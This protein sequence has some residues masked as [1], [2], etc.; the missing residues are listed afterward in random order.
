MTTPPN[1]LP[2]TSPEAPGAPPVAQKSHTL[3]W[4]LGGCG[5][6]LVMFIIVVILGVRSFVKNH[7]RVGPNGEV[8]V[9]MPGGGQMRTGKPRDLGIPV[10][11]NTESSGAEVDVTSPRQ[12]LNMSTA[13]YATTDDAE[14]VDAWYRENLSADY[15]R[16]GPGQKHSLPVN[17]QFPI[18]VQSD[19]ITYV[20]N[21][22]KNGD[23]MKIVVI[24]RMI[25][26]TQI[27]LMRTGEPA[28]Q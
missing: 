3:A 10:Y 23:A 22:S 24:R 8:I 5:T 19:A 16:E 25:R 28:A 12:E 4:V 11:P 17:R 20:A 6:L 1:P 2:Y 14:K 7:V 9:Q 26:R 18:P 15:S 13:A 27:T 21:I